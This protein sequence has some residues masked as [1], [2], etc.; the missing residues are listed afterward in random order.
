M[1][2]GVRITHLHMG[3]LE[4]DAGDISTTPHLFEWASFLPHGPHAA[5]AA[6]THCGPKSQAAGKLKPAST[7]PQHTECTVRSTEYSTL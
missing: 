1:E 2:H 5:N 6:A 4:G 7:T 3:N